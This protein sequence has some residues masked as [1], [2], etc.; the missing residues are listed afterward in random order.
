MAGTDSVLGLLLYRTVGE[1]RFLGLPP[2][3]S[4]KLVANIFS[5]LLGQTSQG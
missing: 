4:K 1:V 2:E 3:L 5:C